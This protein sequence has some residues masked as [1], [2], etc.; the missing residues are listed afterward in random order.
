MDTNDGS[1][2]RHLIW[3]RW[4]NKVIQITSTVPDLSK[5]LSK[6]VTLRIVQIDNGIDRNPNL[7]QSH[8]NQT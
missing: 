1:E 7:T 6:V 3:R 5:F 4:R 8:G 2:F